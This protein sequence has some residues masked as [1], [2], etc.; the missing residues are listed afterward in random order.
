MPVGGLRSSG[1]EKE[2]GMASVEE[3]TKVK[4]IIKN[5]PR[6]SLDE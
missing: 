3:F 2:G 1:Y 4:H 5:A 6:A